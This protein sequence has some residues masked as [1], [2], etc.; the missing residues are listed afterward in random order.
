M[1][2]IMLLDT[3]PDHESL[4]VLPDQSRYRDLTARTAT[5]RRAA[6]IHVVF[7]LPT[8]QAESDTWTP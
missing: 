6:G 7:V 2:A 8:G 4:I 5:G 3:H 1:K